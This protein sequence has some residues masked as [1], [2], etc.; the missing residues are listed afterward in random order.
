MPKG[1]YHCS[2]SPDPTCFLSNLNDVIPA[3]PVMLLYAGYAIL[4]APAV[5]PSQKAIYVPPDLSI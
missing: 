1:K 5:S 2:V 3:I 4:A